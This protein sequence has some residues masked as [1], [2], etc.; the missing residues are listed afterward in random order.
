MMVIIQTQDFR[1]G[2]VSVRTRLS[3][4]DPSFRDHHPLLIDTLRDERLSQAR[5]VTAVTWF[6]L[7]SKH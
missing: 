5:S 6:L 2:R 1:A 7:F 4:D 3:S